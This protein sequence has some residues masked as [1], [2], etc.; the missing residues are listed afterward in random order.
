MSNTM[1]SAET[2]FRKINSFYNWRKAMSAE[3][4]GR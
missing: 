3:L 4:K 2:R 1:S